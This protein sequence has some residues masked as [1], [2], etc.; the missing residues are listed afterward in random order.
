MLCIIYYV[1]N[2]IQKREKEWGKEKV[3]SYKK[4]T[5]HYLHYLR[6]GRGKCRKCKKCKANKY[7]FYTS[8]KNG[9][10][11]FFICPK[12][13]KMNQKL[14][15]GELCELFLLVSCRFWLLPHFRLWWIDLID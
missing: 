8:G 9:R 7:N 6:F 13:P 11:D 4:M 12:L 1:Y 15:N 14:L 10:G 3:R 2:T 5:L